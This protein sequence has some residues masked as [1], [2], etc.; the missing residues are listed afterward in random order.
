MIN[1]NE[2]KNP[3][4]IYRTAPFWAL[5]DLLEEDE[6]K[7]Q[8]QEFKAVGMG[9]AYLHPRGGMVTEYLSEDYWKA[10]EV[11]IKEMARLDMIAWLYDEDR[12]PSGVAGGYVTADKPEYAGK[13]I[14]KDGEIK[15]SEISHRY[16]LQRY[17]DVCSPEAVGEF[18]RLTHDEYYARF[19]EYFGNVIPAIFTDEPYLI[20]E[21]GLP[22]SEGFEDKF[23]ERYGY[24]IASH[25]KELFEDTPDSPKHRLNYWSMISSMFVEAFSKTIYDWC[26]KKGIAYT[27]HFWEHEF[28]SPLASGSVMPH[29]AYMQYPGIDMLFVSDETRPEQYSNDLIVK[30]ASSVANQLGKERVLSETNGAS[31]WGLDF[32]YQKRA[33]DWQLALGINLFCQHLSLYS[34]KGYRKR[35]FPLSYFDHQPWWKDYGILADYIGRMSYALAQGKYQADVLV[36]HPSLSTW[37]HYN[38]PE[39]LEQIEKSV[40]SLTRDLG[41]NRIMY[42]LGD[43]IIMKSHGKVENGRL[44]IGQMSYNVVFIPEMYVMNKST[45]ELLKAFAAEGGKIICTGAAPDLLDGEPSNE[46]KNFFAKR[47]SDYVL[48][49]L[50]VSMINLI[51]ANGKPINQ[52]YG[53]MRQLSENESLIFLCNLD[54]EEALNLLM[55]LGG[56]YGVIRLNGETGEAYPIS[57]DKTGSVRFALQPLESALFIINTAESGQIEEAISKPAAKTVLPLDNWS[58]RIKDYNAVNL[59]FA[60]VSLDGGAYS[61]IGDVLEIDDHLKSQLNMEPGNINMRQPWMYSKAE[62]EDLHAAKVVYTFTIG[63]MPPGK[64]MAA[65]EQP[66]LWTVFVN[67]N[68]VQPT[69][70]YYIDKAFV[71]YDI[72]SHV[73]TG[74]NIIRIET[75][76]YGVLINLESIYIVGE[77]ALKC[78]VICPPE[79]LIIGDITK[80]GYLYYSGRVEYNAT[81]TLDDEFTGGCLTFGKWHG[82]TA[83][84]YINGEKIKTVGWPPYKVA[85]DKMR[86]GE[87]KITIEIANSL[88]NLMGPFGADTNQNLVTPGSFYTKKHE[89][90]FPLGFDG[91]AALEIGGAQ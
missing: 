11:C 85:I 10:M 2:F 51:E 1:M 80:Q 9:G 78:D 83:T 48:G 89:V 20:R 64:V 27:G 35:D 17:I 79:A 44:S 45:F 91:E 59:Q 75:T 26:D 76:K 7:R 13:Y 18:V 36:L 62:I 15:Q 50:D 88:Q 67:D 87:N 5:N 55:P 22:W 46:L 16:N 30:E 81:V 39:K 82:V 60:K 38:S 72:K 23:K 70:Q 32:A 49:D 8:I 74:E 24:D 73:K 4:S 41:A 86:K 58:V 3:A 42:D 61:E 47:P 52:V 33:T 68:L 21:N 90:F 34:M 43:E 56:T 65:V 29:Y 66:E 19:K 40:K 71:L 25:V 57:I 6:L 12:F 77:F 37:I 69:N 84:V 14:T 53:H 31:G 54:M 28:P 63:E